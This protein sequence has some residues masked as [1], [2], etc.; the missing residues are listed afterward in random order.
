MSRLEYACRIDSAIVFSTT[1]FSGAVWAACIVGPYWCRL[2]GV[3]DFVMESSEEIATLSNLLSSFVGC[4]MGVVC[5][6]VKIEP[7]ARLA[8][9]TLLALLLFV[10][11][12]LF[13]PA[14]ASA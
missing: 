4:V 7:P 2:V 8:D 3:S 11:D 13:F 5:F 1:S 9:C 10:V 6:C 14:I 12:F